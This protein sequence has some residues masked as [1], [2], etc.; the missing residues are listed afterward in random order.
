MVDGG[1]IAIHDY[2]NSELP[3]V[4]RAVN[5]FFEAHSDEYDFRLVE[6]LAILERK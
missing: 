2:R 6:T 1:I 5:E 4:A 3:G